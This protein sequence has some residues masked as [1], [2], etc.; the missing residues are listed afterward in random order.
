MTFLTLPSLRYRE[1]YLQAMQEFQAEGMHLEYSLQRMTS[2]FED[3]LNYL[4]ALQ[5]RDKVTPGRV[6]NTEFWLIANAEFIGQLNLR[7]TLNDYLLRVGGH[8]GYEIR[9]SRRRQGY[10]KEIL[11]LGLQEAKAIGLQRVL[12]TCDENNIGSRKIIE[13]NGG[14]L[15]NIITVEGYPQRKRRYWITIP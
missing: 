10:G 1:S 11:Q 6:P 7:H 4:K 12:L 5:E 9:P 2:S 3:Y 13:H 15:E 8:I 14:I